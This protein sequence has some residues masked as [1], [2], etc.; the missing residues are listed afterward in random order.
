MIPVTIPALEATA[1]LE[2]VVDDL[3]SNFKKRADE[4]WPDALF[5]GLKKQPA[6]QRLAEYA[7]KTDVRDM[8]LLLDDDYLKYF[9]AG[10]APAPVS[11]YW[12]TLLSVPDVF[13]QAR[14]DFLNLLKEY[15]P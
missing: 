4:A 15:V 7:D 10:S 11:P 2:E 5:P 9:Q 12:I 8:P 6:P 14:D 13:K 1:I 3:V